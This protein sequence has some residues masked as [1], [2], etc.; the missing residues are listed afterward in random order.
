MLLAVV[1]IPIWKNSAALV[2]LSFWRFRT[3]VHRAAR[4]PNMDDVF[5]MFCL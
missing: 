3:A 5:S 2:S 1:L 4:F